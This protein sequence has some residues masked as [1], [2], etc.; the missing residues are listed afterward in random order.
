MQVTA[1]S[2]TYIKQSFLNLEGI[3][4]V[5]YVK[6]K[7]NVGINPYSAKLHLNLTANQ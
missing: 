3:T 7:K 4:P 2:H 5:N 1:R 6:E